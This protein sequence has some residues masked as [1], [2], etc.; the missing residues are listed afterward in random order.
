MGENSKSHEMW[1]KI[2]NGPNSDVLFDAC[3][4]AHRKAAKVDVDFL[5][6]SDCTERER[7]CVMIPMEIDD[8]VIRGI[9]HEDWSGEKLILYGYC[10]TNFGTGACG[11]DRM[12][13]LAFEARYH[14]RT[15]KGSITFSDYVDCEYDMAGERPC[16]CQSCRQN[17]D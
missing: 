9:Q 15:H 1:F 8:V 11:C 12:R 14:A 4:Y 7:G 13:H 10:Y 6:A 17:R 16:Q 2:E 5:I 3:K